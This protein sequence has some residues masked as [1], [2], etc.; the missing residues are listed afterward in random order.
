MAAEGGKKGKPVTLEGVDRTVR[1][2]QAFDSK[3]SFN[4]VEISRKVGLSE[5]TALRYLTSLVSAGFV[6]RTEA[7]RY[8]LGWELFRLGQTAVANRVPRQAALPVM[9]GLLDQYN[10][11]VNLAVRE[12]DRLVIVEALEGDRSLKKVTQIGQRDPWHASA[13]GKSMLALMPE[14]E[15]KALLARTGTPKLM[16]NTLSTRAALEADLAKTRER[17]YAVDLQ[18]SEED[19]TCFGAAIAGR[20]GEPLFAISISFVAFRV[21]E[22]DYDSV[23]GAVRDAAAKLRARLG[24]EQ[25]VGV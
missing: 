18:E 2:L 6:E 24:L 16:K 4:L 20:E 3:E 9:E 8:R 22:A 12:G 14:D 7:G 21:D 10:E 11:T 15:R 25:P 1:V 5:A 23:G 13:L 17:G 19:L